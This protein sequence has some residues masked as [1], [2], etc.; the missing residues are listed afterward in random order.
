MSSEWQINEALSRVAVKY[1]K[2]DSRWARHSDPGWYSRQ[3]G[4]SVCMSVVEHEKH[5]AWLHVSCS[6][7]ARLPSYKDITEVKRRFIGP[8]IGAIE[9]Y[10]AVDE[11]VN[12]HPFCRHLW[13]R[14]DGRSA[15]DFR[16][17]G[18]V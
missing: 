1:V 7:P 15:P 8:D 13:A 14:L 10:A 16:V 12:I 6:Y 18:Q 2:I 11:H 4:L 5:G 9:V 17:D 3:D